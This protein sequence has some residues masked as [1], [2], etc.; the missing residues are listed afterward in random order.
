M[1][2]Q[3]MLFFVMFLISLTIDPMN[4]MVYSFDSIYL[5][6]SLIISSLYMA[7]TMICAHQIVH[8]ISMGH[9]D[10]YV[11]SIGIGL[12]AVFLYIMRNQIF[13]KPEDW[14]RGMI[15]HHS[16]AITTTRKLLEN[17]Q[18]QPDSNIY[19]LANDILKTQQDEIAFM[20]ELLQ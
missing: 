9:L 10:K 15:P 18:L 4:V 14:M 20:K 2:E 5:S 19:K 3:V 17:N 12:S 13:I 8:Y 6:K 1:R 11:F 16:T 7:S